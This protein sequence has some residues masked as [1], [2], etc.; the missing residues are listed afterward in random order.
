MTQTLLFVTVVLLAQAHAFADGGT[1]QMR[2][3]AGALLI[4]VF[5]SPTPLSAGPADISVLVQNRDGLAPVLDARVS[6]LL[7]REGSSTEIRAHATREQAQNKLL[8]AALVTVPESGKWQLSVTTLHNAF[9]TE[10]GGEIR[11]TQGHELAGSYWGYLAFPPVM[12]AVFVI[13]EWLIRRR[14]NL[15]VSQCKII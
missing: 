5:T 9:R 10:I 15:Q 14:P 4:T 13:R 1:V 3:E 12:I 2:K 7:R 6:V 11:V 8:Y